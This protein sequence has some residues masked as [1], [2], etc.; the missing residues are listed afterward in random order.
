MK[1]TY[2]IAETQ[3]QLSKLCRG[4]SRFVIARR[5]K[6]VYVAMPIGDFDALLETLD[7]LSNLKAMR[8]LRAAKAGRLKYTPLKLDREDL[9]L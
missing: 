6:P 5:G 2:S 1:D 8:T 4:K 9:R 3:A 7:L